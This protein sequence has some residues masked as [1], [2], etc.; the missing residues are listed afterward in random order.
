MTV[1][2]LW[3]RDDLTDGE[4]RGADGLHL[5]VASDSRITSG[6]KVST[7]QAPKILP[8]HVVCWHRRPDGTPPTSYFF[9]TFGYAFA[10]HVNICYAVYSRLS[11]MLYQLHATTQALPSLD[12]IAEIALKFMKA[13]FED[14]LKVDNDPGQTSIILFGYDRGTERKHVFELQCWFDQPYGPASVKTVKSKRIEHLFDVPKKIV[15]IGSGKD[16]FLNKLKSATNDSNNENDYYGIVPSHIMDNELNPFGS[17]DPAVGG[18][19][20][21]GYCGNGPFRVCSVASSD[22]KK[23]F[24]YLGL[25]NITH[26]RINALQVAMEAM[27]VRLY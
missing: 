5:C 9:H 3:M 27:V 19:L 17:D 6:E 8:L 11:A 10:G 20:Q 25:S 14:Y 18:E 13:Y 22:P 16:S 26:G 12:G 15:V 1:V 2:C 23:A 4:D 21:V 7:D 24:A